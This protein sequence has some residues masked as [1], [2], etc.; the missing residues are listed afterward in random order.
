MF[1]FNTGA[2][3]VYAIS[4]YS[5]TLVSSAATITG[6]TIN[7]TSIGA[8]TASSGRFTTLEATGNTILGDASGDTITANA[9]TMSVPNNLYF[10]GTGTIRLPNGTTGERP[11]PTVGMV[12][13]N[14]TTAGFEGYT[15]GGWGNIGGGASAN[16]AIYENKNSIS[17][18]YTLT[19]NY[20]GMSVGPLTIDAGVV[21]TVPTGQRW[22]IL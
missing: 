13:Y 19:T 18:S 14:T 5:G 21:V 15:A 12:R 11:S 1:V 16:G 10:S 7:S 20:N 9:G 17:S 22:V 3:V 8:S 4:Y 2:N 6:G